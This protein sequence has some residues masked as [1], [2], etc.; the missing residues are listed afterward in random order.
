VRRRQGVQQARNP[1]GQETRPRCRGELDMVRKL[2]GGA[3]GAGV[4]GSTP[5]RRG[6]G[7][8]VTSREKERPR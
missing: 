3:R 1:C 8:F 4:L 2:R 7:Q 5:T 6:W